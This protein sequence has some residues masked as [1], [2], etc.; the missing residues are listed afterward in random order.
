MKALGLDRRILRAFYTQYVAVL[1]IILVFFVAAFQTATSAES[2]RFRERKMY[3]R[4]DAFGEV[5]LSVG[6]MTSGLSPEDDERLRALAEVLK[7]HDV[8]ATVELIVTRM[9]LRE[10]DNGA[11]RAATLTE[12][13]D[14]FFQSHAVPAG[15]VR[16]TIKE[17][18]LGRTEGGT[19]KIHRMDGGH[20]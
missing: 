12:Q 5:Q 14:Q 16:Y 3:T 2:P 7:T 8:T 1:L 6:F 17:R 15:A 9:A 4:P 13:L 19:V 18:A 10:V 11:I 20:E